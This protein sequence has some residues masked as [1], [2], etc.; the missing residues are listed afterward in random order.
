[1]SLLS[2]FLRPQEVK[3]SLAALEDLVEVFESPVYPEIR[4]LLAR[5]IKD[6]PKGVV[7][8]VR[9]GVPT[10]QYVCAMMVNMLASTLETGSLHVYRGVLSQRGQ[11]ALQLFHEGAAE[12]KAIGIEDP[13]RIDKIT[14]DLMKNIQEVG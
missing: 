12:L 13:A 14:S 6:D 5:A 1:M 3:D 9:G 4:D 8:V 10:R 11:W 2:R 7:G